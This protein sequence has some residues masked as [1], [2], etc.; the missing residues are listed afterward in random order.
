MAE[1]TNF[2]QEKTS[3]AGSRDKTRIGRDL[4]ESSARQT[5]EAASQQRRQQRRGKRT[6]REG[7]RS[8]G[9]HLRSRELQADDSRRFLVHE[10]HHMSKTP[11]C[12]RHMGRS[13]RHSHWKPPAPGRTWVL[14]PPTWRSGVWVEAGGGGG[15]ASGAPRGGRSGGRGDRVGV[16]G[17]VGG[18][19]AE[20]EAV[21][22]RSE[23]EGVSEEG[24]PSGAPSGVTPHLHA[25]TLT[26]LH[27][28][29]TSE[30]R[31]TFN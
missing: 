13:S 27:Y 11:G 28:I 21:R 10:L 26:W 12:Q 20:H 4:E 8:S 19:D 18:H 22:R 31:P 6:A 23:S 3:S 25:G 14:P 2:I 1:N 24:G 17:T 5:E 9:T 30:S 16:A 29:S 15:G 7:G